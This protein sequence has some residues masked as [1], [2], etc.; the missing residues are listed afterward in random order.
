MCLG[1]M[2]R[3]FDTGGGGI[4]FAVTNVVAHAAVEEEHVLRDYADLA[5]QAV[6]AYAC[7]VRAVD[8][9]MP[10]VRL[11]QAHEQVGQSALAGAILASE[12]HSFTR[13]NMQ[14][15]FL[16]S[17]GL[18]LLAGLVVAA[19]VVVRL[20]RGEQG[21]L[22]LDRLKLRMPVMGPIVIMVAICRFCRIL[23][24]MLHN[25]VP[26]LQALSISKDSAG[27]QILAEEIGKAAESV[28]KGESLAVPLG[29]SGMFP[30]DVVDMIAVAEESNNL[31][32]V[33]VQIADSNE[34]RTG[35]QIDL[36]VRLLEPL[37][38]MFM[39][40]LVLVIA[41]ALLVPI[42]RMSAAGR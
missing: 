6:Q 12:S 1:R 35:R 26:I 31:E 5:A 38:L 18:Y 40:C 34:A 13:L 9:N 37:M 42:L 10:G 21:R 25:G 7:D 27:N 30:A 39:A 17:S 20:V 15:Y 2:G 28:Q 24:T 36:G 19:L 16:Q 4:E 33:L 32:T 29:S 8:E 3:A 14:V 41:V 23:G 11:M 22:A